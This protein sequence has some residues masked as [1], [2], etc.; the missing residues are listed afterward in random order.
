[1]SQAPVGR[2]ETLARWL[3]PLAVGGFLLSLAIGLLVPVYTDEIGW[4]FQERAAADGGFDMMFSDAC[5]PSTI[6]RAPWFMMP[7]RLFS[8]VANRALADPLFVRITGVICA[9]L[10]AGLLWLLTVQLERDLARRAMVQALTFGLLGIGVLPFLLVLSRPEQPLILTATLMVL[11]VFL[12]PPAANERVLAWIKVAAIVLLASIALSYHLKG[13]LYAALALVCIA[14]CARGRATLA[15]R[16]AGM[17]ALVALALGAAH[18]WVGRFRCPGDAKL[19]AIL[20]RENVAA[21]IARG[22][23]L[24]HLLLRMAEGANPWRYVEQTLPFSRPMSSWIAPGLFPAELPDVM[25]IALMA[26][27]AAIALVVALDLCWF[28]SRERLRALAEPRLMLAL[29]ILGC[30][31]GWG[32]SQFQLH[33]Y[34]AGHVLP[35]LVIAVLLASALPLPRTGW[36]SLALPVLVAAAV[37]FALI[38][39]A[40]V[41]ASTVPSLV[42]AARTPGYPAAQP[43]SVSIS[44]YDGIRRDIAR[45]MAASG[46][47]QDRRLHRLL[48]DDVTYLALQHSSL[49][50]HRLG[51]LS[52][53]NGGIKDPVAYLISRN[54]DGVVIGCHYLPG[55]MREAAA[56]SGPICALSRAGLD[57]LARL[58]PVM[59]GRP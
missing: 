5:G 3:H 53:W 39:Q 28:L 6:A 15:P 47:P 20:D 35:M 56:R 30:M 17:A 7:V 42:K 14:V 43:F 46:M 2:L 31:L 59:R 8:A 34:E 52:I 24:G 25:G 37:P 27:W 29:A 18:Y 23:S 10:W 41:L 4:R 1:M 36:R 50:L 22:G 45:A 44:G 13:V 33:V 57:R 16:L 38:S 32:A 9:L 11:L 54:S 55:A 26:L 58:D 49:P 40:F 51:V 12:R 19:A 21:L 48:I